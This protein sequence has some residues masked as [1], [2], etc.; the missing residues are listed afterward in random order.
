MVLLALICA[1]IAALF[2]TAIFQLLRGIKTANV[3]G[4]IVGVV[5]I[6]L[7]FVLLYYVLMTLVLAGAQ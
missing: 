6:I 2:T 4:V 7:T 5:L 3:R 1:I